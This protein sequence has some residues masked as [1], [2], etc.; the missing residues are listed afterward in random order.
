MKKIYISGK[1]TGLDIA[2]AAMLFGA[3]HEELEKK[4]YHPVNP[5]KEVPYNKDWTWHQYM[6]ADIALIFDC[7]H[8]YMLSNWKESKGAR[9]EHAI[10]KEL[11]M[12]IIYQ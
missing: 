4:N 11:E 3:A 1:I 12:E 10:A 8:M 2:I 5:M 6:L 9:M 7:T